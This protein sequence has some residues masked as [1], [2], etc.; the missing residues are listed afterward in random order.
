METRNLQ[1]ARKGLIVVHP[2]G[3][4]LSPKGERVTFTNYWARRLAA[5]DVVETKEFTPRATA[6]K[7]SKA[8]KPEKS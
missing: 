5:G 3:R 7:G 2:T 1:P 6:P 4:R 8:T